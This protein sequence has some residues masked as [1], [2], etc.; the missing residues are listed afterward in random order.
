MLS[1][2]RWTVSAAALMSPRPTSLVSLN[3]LWRDESIRALRVGDLSGL[4]ALEILYLDNNLLTE[5]P[6]DIFT[7]LAALQILSLNNNNLEALPSGVFTNLA[8]LN[9]LLLNANSLTA[10]PAGLFSGLRALIYIL[11]LNNPGSE[12]FLPIA[13]AGADR[14][15]DAG[16]IA[17]LTAT[18]SDA[19]PW[20]DNV[21]YAWAQI[22][23]G[24]GV[25][26]LK[27]GKTARP[28]F[29]MP[30][31]A[32]ALEF[33]L[34]VTGRGGVLYSDTDRV[35]VRDPSAVAPVCDRTE[36]V[37]DAIVAAVDG[38]GNCADITK[39]HLAGITQLFLDDESISALQADD[40]L[41]P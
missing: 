9:F 7:G 6:S 41:R 24:G 25:V 27:D 38:V 34:T 21:S 26:T 16:Q 3:Y 32:T 20:G 35:T 13:N 39:A 37:R 5:L 28:S 17:T 11:L 15:V 33:E 18:A 14:V 30:A 22:D 1:S 12:D 31:G 40:F 23:N 4:A 29:V 2:Q 8:E 10:L 36:Q 19:D